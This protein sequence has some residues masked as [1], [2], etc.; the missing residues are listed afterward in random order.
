MSSPS[1]IRPL[2]AIPVLRPDSTQ[3]TSTTPPSVLYIPPQEKLWVEGKLVSGSVALRP[4]YFVDEPNA[5]APL[6]GAWVPLGRDASTGTA[7]TAFNAA[8]YSGAAN[9]QYVGRRVGAYFVL[10]EESP[11][12]PVYDF[13]HLSAQ[14][15]V[16]S[17]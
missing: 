8:T 14:L 7:A 12:S 15:S 13:I 6:Y 17:Q 11:S 10:V 3:L 1:L 9:G 2:S 4:Y 5:S 16:S